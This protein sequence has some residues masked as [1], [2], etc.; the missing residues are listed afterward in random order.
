MPAAPFMLGDLRIDAAEIAQRKAFLTLD[1]R[2]ETILAS[3]HD[4]LSPH[5][6]R[7]IE[8]FYRHLQ[9][10][11]EMRPL[12]G[13]EIKL[14]RMKRSQ[15]V[16]F[17]QLTEGC[18]DQGY[19]DNRLHVGIVHQRV[20]L[21]PKWYLSAYYK[22]FSEVM[23]LIMTHHAND[24]ALALD[25][26]RAMLKVI[27]FDMGLALD[28]YFHTEQQTLRL[29]H[30]YTEQIIDSMPIGFTVLDT[31]GR[32]RMA[33]NTFL[34]MFDLKA[35]KDWRGP[36]LGDMLGIDTMSDKIGQVFR[37]GKH[38]KDYGFERQT[39]GK[40][41]AYLADISIA[42]MGEDSVA[43]F[44]VQDITLRK[45]SEEKIQHMAFYDLL[46]QLPNRRL[47]QE[48][49]TQSMAIGSRT[50]KHGALMFIDLDN[51][52]VLND[53]QGHDAGD[54]LLK[55][56]ANRLT[57]NVR[58]GDTVARL[59]GDEFVV[60]LESL[61]GTPLEAANHAETI[62]EKIR[63]ELSLPYQLDG[64]EHHTSPS[65]GVSVFCGHQYSLDEVLKQADMAMYQAKASGRNTVCFFDPAMQTEMERRTELEKDLRASIHRKQLKLHYQMQVDDSGRIV[66]AEALIRWHHPRRGLILPCEFIQ[67]A[68]EIGMII[69]IGDWVIEQA[70]A[71]LKRWEM[72]PALRRLQLSVNVS[73][74]QLSQPWF[75]EQVRE[76]VER[77]GIR[78]SL[79]K[80]ELTESFILD[81]VEDSIE[82]MQE[83]RYLGIRFAMDDFGTGY[84]SLAYLKRLPLEQLKI[85]RS[86]LHDI[87][88]DRNNG[89]MVRTIIDIARNFGLE[90]VAEGVEN[91]EQHAFLRQY[92]CN[93][94]QGYLFG[95]PM[96]AEEFER[97]CLASEEART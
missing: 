1:H 2:D 40:S 8:E 19:V 73:P 80:L 25:A 17:S 70:C 54:L 42:H 64:I 68:E 83:L 10:F 26:L 88:R 60:V 97:H 96:P 75:V 86:F 77:S 66:G 33:N 7:L 69:P 59:G 55:A 93:R 57:H 67:L 71:Q 24:P 12:L 46:T 47:L 39:D 28:T 45:R 29:A 74:R 31:D 4:A 9:R 32:V 3:L 11:P 41:H 18:Y 23:P 38:C 72:S 63:A 5:R 82:K 36:T 76:A 78:P 37:S 91:D 94:Y 51:F 92:G 30:R 56:V 81:D 49:L 34:K 14:V 15:E 50:E 58:E 61:G 13:D 95:Q 87:N 48:R 65:I 84:S 22:Y 20:G 89:I 79:L 44:M 6:G 43:L 35:D 52:K 16:Y 27:F 85:D 53:T 90:I 62:A 21:T